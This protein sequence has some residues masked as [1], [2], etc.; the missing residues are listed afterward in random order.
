MKL[1]LDFGNTK[2]KLALFDEKSQPEILVTE[3]PG[4]SSLKAIFES[5][6]GIQSSILSSVAPY[7]SE[8]DDFLLAKSHFIKLTH[9]T[10]LP[11]AIEYLT[12]QTL[13]K[14]R[15]AAVAGALD[16]FPGHPILVIDAGT[17]ITY[18]LITSQLQ[19]LG[20]GISP[21]IQ[22][23]FKALHNFTGSLPLVENATNQEHQLIGNSTVSCISSGVLNGVLAEVNG[24]INQYKARFEGLK[25]V[26]SGGDYKYFEKYIK[27]DIFATPNIVVQGLKNILDFN[28]RS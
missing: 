26:V 15:I 12:P 8:I 3:N 4:L 6:P 28:E 11:F 19:Y 5:N 18:D 25:V 10:P 20:G 7:P 13:G 16:Y 24:I 17:S 14:D 23:R 22:M 2:A 1:V 27:N 9:Q 21:G